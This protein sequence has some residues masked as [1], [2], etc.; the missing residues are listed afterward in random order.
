MQPLEL[1]GL[2]TLYIVRYSKIYFRTQCFGDLICLHSQV[3]EETPTLLGS[4]E[5]A[6]LNHWANYVSITTAA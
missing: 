4:L 5:I 2:W 3:R 1:L 6:N